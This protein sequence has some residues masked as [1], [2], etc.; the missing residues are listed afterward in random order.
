MSARDIYKEKR[1][2]RKREKDNICVCLR[3]GKRERRERE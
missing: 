2:A 3:K 1:E